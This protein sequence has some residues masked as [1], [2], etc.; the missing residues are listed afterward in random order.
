MEKIGKF[1]E[2]P[3]LSLS[4]FFE[5]G[6]A[7]AGTGERGTVFLKRVHEAPKYDIEPVRNKS[8]SQL[9]RGKYQNQ[10]FFFNNKT[11]RIYT[12][13]TLNIDEYSRQPASLYKLEANTVYFLRDYKAGKSVRVNF[14]P[15]YLPVSAFKGNTVFCPA[16]RKYEPVQETNRTECGLSVRGFPV[17]MD[18]DSGVFAYKV[19]VQGGCDNL[20]LIDYI[21][22]DTNQNRTEAYRRVINIREKDTDSVCSKK[23]PEEVYDFVIRVLVTYTRNMYGIDLSYKNFRERDFCKAIIKSPFEPALFFLK[24][25]FPQVE[26]LKEIDLKNPGCFKV[27]CDRLG[28]KAYRTFRRAFNESL[29]AAPCFYIATKELKFQDKNII[30]EMLFAHEM[31]ALIPNSVFGISDSNLYDLDLEDG[32][33]PFTYDTLLDD[34]PAG[35]GFETIERPPEGYVTLDNGAWGLN[36]EAHIVDIE[37]FAAAR[38]LD[39]PASEDIMELEEDE[40]PTVPCIF[41]FYS[42]IA[43]QKSE[44]TAWNLL[45][46]IYAPM[47]RGMNQT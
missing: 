2:V 1:G 26:G 41:R 32:N 47:R 3:L 39:R 40:D 34:V 16:H 17:Q 45:K 35:S 5:N 42:K 31:D 30:N 28:I 13:T 7:V 27:F 22:P 21:Y 24:D 11:G 37:P 8:T 18:E 43:R 10:D 12:A 15:A 38:E 20:I 44:R 14:N 36:N 6:F 46:K 25:M 29:R 23:L 4:K 33:L 19:T 9:F